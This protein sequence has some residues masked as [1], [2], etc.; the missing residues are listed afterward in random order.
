MLRLTQAPRRC[1][2]NAILVNLRR[3]CAVESISRNRIKQTGVDVV[4]PVSATAIELALVMGGF[5]T[6]KESDVFRLFQVY[7]M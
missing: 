6:F 1:F 4:V 2:L 5:S 3:K 7:G